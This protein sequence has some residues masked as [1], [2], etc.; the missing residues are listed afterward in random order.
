MKK[1]IFSAMIFGFAGL[2]TTNANTINLNSDVATVQDSTTRTSVK[3]EELPEPVKAT[4]ASEAY[5]VWK[6]TA[7]FHVKTA[8]GTEYYQIN[9]KKDE[10]EGSI[11]LDAQ[12]KPVE[13]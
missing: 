2:A 8:T 5:K 1:L 4:L 13:G 3:L 7:A 6:P 10:E 9:V 11:M 12:G